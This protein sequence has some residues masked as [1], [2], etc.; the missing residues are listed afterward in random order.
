MLTTVDFDDEAPVYAIEV[1]DVRSEWELPPEL[2]AKVAGTNVM[3]EDGFG[4]CGVTAESSSAG[5][6]G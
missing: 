2:R 5:Y 4:V 1:K 3:P 6:R